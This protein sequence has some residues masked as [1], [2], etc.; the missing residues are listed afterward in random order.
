M[1]TPV[2]SS[3]GDERLASAFDTDILDDDQGLGV[4]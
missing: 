4:G 3:K 2:S 1:S